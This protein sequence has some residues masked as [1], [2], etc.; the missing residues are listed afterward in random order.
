MGS[1]LRLTA[2]LIVRAG[3]LV[4]RDS[5]SHD[6]PRYIPSVSYHTL[7]QSYEQRT[8]HRSSS[9]AHTNNTTISQSTPYSPT[10]TQATSVLTVESEEKGSHG[11]LDTWHNRNGAP[12][13]PNLERPSNSH[14]VSAYH[15]ID[16][17]TKDVEVKTSI[18]SNGSLRGPSSGHRSIGKKSS[19]FNIFHSW[20][21]RGTRTEASP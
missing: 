20:K 2:S 3:E 19:K 18:L 11:Q 10:G 14:H 15:G 1:L 5:K 16:Q 13:I 7:N 4:L 6:Q 21:R 8:H 17:G 12:D 9:G